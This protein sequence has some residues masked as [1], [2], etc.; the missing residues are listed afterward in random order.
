MI[1]LAYGPCAL[2]HDDAMSKPTSTNPFP[3]LVVKQRL[4]QSHKEEQKNTSILT[5]FRTLNNRQAGIV[6]PASLCYS[7]SGGLYISDNN[8]Q[9]IQYW[10]SDS[11]T[12]KVFTTERGNG[13][14][15]FPNTI[16][17]SSSR[18]FVSDNDGIKT[19]SPEGHLER[20]TRSFFGVSSFTVTDKGTILA[21]TLIRNSADDD[22]L[23]VEIE[24]SGKQLRVFGVR[25]NVA[26][27]NGAEDVAFVAVSKTVMFAAFRH[28]PTV[29]IYDLESGR[30][31]Q[32]LTVDHP[33]FRDLQKELTRE[34]VSE[35]QQPDRVF[36]PRYVAGIRVV[37]NRIFLCLH[38]PE[39]EVWEIDRQGNPVAEFRIAGLA[40]A[41]DIFGFDVRIDEGNLLFAVGTIDQQWNAT[42]SETKISPSL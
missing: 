30:L 10:P 17:W 41:V 22:P 12:A 36:L 21:N 38:L 34:N 32:K 1:V 25:R 26:G 29:E 27:H 18:I 20:L 24:P 2:K 28:H 6:F 37:D 14:L 4:Q 40:P 5:P 33:V 39:P 16:R 11:T 19:F 42:V 31:I 35:G 9:K 13:E 3:E 23:I 15:K 7:D 8:G